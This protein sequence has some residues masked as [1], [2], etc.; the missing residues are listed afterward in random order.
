MGG[1]FYLFLFF[2][3]R[4]VVGGGE[5]EL[6]Q[7]T[8]NEANTR[9]AKLIAHEIE[10]SFTTQTHGYKPDHFMKSNASINPRRRGAIEGHEIIHVL[11]HQ[12]EG[13]CFVTY[14]GLIMTLCIGN[15]FL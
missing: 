1:L 8:N 14:K 7:E 2:F 3:L 6:E 5:F 12:P 15:T 9:M 11:V 13:N 4:G 10:V